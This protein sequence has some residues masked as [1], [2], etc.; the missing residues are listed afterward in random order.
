MHS[1]FFFFGKLPPSLPTPLYVLVECLTNHSVF[2][3]VSCCLVVKAEFWPLPILTFGILAL[4][5]V[6]GWFCIAQS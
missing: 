3:R 6:W 1:V 4:V 5:L 2:G